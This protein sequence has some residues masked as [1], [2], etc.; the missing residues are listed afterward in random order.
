MPPTVSDAPVVLLFDGECNLCNATVTF[1]IARDRRQVFS[2]AP[3][4]S[5]A[6]ERLLADVGDD[7]RER[8]ERSASTSSDGE[9][10]PWQS[11]VLI[12][13]GRVYRRSTAAL[14]VVRHLTPPWSVLAIF[15]IVPAPLRDAIYSFIAR[16]RYRWFGR[17][18]TR[19]IPTPELRARFLE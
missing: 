7:E 12:E 1:V 10:D 18:D 11:V 13:R 5:R 15:L 14:R 3:L 2:F 8:R 9:R 4:Q 17:R 19:M 6:A 16:H